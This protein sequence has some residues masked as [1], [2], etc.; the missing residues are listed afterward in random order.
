MADLGPGK[1]NLRPGKA[2]LKSEEGDLKT[3]KANSRLD[4]EGRDYD[5]KQKKIAVWNHR[6]SALP[7]S[8]PPPSKE[9]KV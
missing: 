6:S 8:L 7:G 2:D 9:V 5:R 4:Y 3:G 1:A